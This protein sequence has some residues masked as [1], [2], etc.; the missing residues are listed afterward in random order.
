MTLMY[1]ETEEVQDLSGETYESLILM[2][3][4]KE[5]LREMCQIRN[6]RYG[7]NKTDLVQRLHCHVVEGN[8]DPVTMWSNFIMANEP[9]DGNKYEAWCAK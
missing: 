6:L 3:Q 2:A 1:M 8:I 9:K 7:G 4:R 5:E